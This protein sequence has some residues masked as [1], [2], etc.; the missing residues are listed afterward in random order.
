MARNK[1][2]DKDKF[3]TKPST[4]IKLISLINLKNYDVV[5]E[6][7]AGNGSFSNNITHQNILSFVIWMV[8]WLILI[9]VM[10]I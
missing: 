4:A 1:K 3:Y 7:S 2:H 10:K 9:K 6:P 8:Y 5:I